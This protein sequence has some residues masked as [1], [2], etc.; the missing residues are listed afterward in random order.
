MFVKFV[1]EARS[2]SDNKYMFFGFFILHLLAFFFLVRP[3]NTNIWLAR[4][5]DNTNYLGLS[6]FVMRDNFASGFLRELPDPRI[7]EHSEW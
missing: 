3:Q 4:E 7:K 1:S 5:R 2:S 6:A